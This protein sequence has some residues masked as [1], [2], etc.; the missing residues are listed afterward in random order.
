M[1]GQVN[2]RGRLDTPSV[3]GSLG[4]LL[5]LSW[6]KSGWG[7]HTPVSV[8]VESVTVRIPRTPVVVVYFD[9]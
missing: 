4:R 2:T 9:V 8:E 6:S 3:T 7:S 5:T 1:S